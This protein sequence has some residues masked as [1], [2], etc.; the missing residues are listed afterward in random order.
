MGR[1]EF[2]SENLP[3]PDT[4][5]HLRWYL[6]HHWEKGP[7]IDEKMCQTNPHFSWEMSQEIAQIQTPEYILLRSFVQR[8]LGLQGWS[9][10]SWWNPQASRWS[11]RKDNAHNILWHFLRWYVVQ[12]GPQEIAETC[13]RLYLHHGDRRGRLERGSHLF[14]FLRVATW[15]SSK[16]R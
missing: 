12:S 8:R 4:V 1:Q 13:E 2:K 14:Y 9:T 15:K 3:P 6:Q 7:E 11:R 5:S 16:S 10:H